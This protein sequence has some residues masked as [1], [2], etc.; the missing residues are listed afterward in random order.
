MT[1]TGNFEVVL[2]TH[3]KYTKFYCPDH[4]MVQAMGFNSCNVSKTF[5]YQ[6]LP[7]RCLSAQS[8]QYCRSDSTS[9]EVSMSQGRRL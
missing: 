5:S 8:C 2:Y 6:R 4:S 9:F 1:E 7:K 3:R